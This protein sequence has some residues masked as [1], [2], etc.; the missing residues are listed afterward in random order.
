[1]TH[2][3]LTA[4]RNNILAT[5]LGGQRIIGVKN[6]K[7]IINRIVRNRRVVL[8]GHEKFKLIRRLSVSIGKMKSRNPDPI[9]DA[10]RIQPVS[11]YQ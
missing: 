6:A 8:T 1:M 10:L 5:E 9:G 4:L 7:P 3:E 11:N 2:D